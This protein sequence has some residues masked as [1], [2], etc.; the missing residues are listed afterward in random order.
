MGLLLGI[1]TKDDTTAASG[2][3]RQP[4]GEIIKEVL[5]VVGSDV[6]A[7]TAQAM[8]E[9]KFFRTYEVEIFTNDA[10]LL[11][12]LKPPI[13]VQPTA[14]KRVWHPAIRQ[15][16]DVPTGG[17][18]NQ[19]SILYGLFMFRYWR[20]KYVASLPGTEALIDECQ[21]SDGYKAATGLGLSGCCV[22][23][24]EGIWAAA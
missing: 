18:P 10:R 13:R 8:K 19:W 23:L 11:A 17:D 16:V 12:F 22:R 6:F 2:T 15:M 21:K 4:H 9:A 20:I 5:G 24:H 7:V 1:Y 3:M 14:T